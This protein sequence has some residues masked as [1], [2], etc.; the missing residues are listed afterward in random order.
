M[1]AK[2]RISIYIYIYDVEIR[3]DSSL[4]CRENKAWV[5]P[6]A[7]REDDTLKVRLIRGLNDPEVNDKNKR[8]SRIERIY[9]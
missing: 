9:S 3:Y 1:P 8:F 6:S 5:S 4:E 7:Y 2:N